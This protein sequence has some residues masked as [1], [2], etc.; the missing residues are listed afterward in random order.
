MATYIMFM[1]WTDQGASDIVNAKKGRDAGKK[2]AEAV[3]VHWKRSYLVM[4]EYDVIVVVEAPNEE[5][6]A[7]FALLGQMSGAVN[8][9]T[10]RAFTESEADELVGSLNGLTSVL[11]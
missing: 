11:A 4:G 6:M 7:K 10:V 2:A 9:K 3:G 1:K 8:I 5:T